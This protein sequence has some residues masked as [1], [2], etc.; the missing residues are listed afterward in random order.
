MELQCLVA[1]RRTNQETTHLV[2]LARARVIHDLLLD[3]IGDYEAPRTHHVERYLG[4]THC[5][6]NEK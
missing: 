5:N 4:S 2:G 3:C 1:T 6:G